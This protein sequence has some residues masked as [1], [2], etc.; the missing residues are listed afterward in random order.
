MCLK[1]NEL[2]FQ[3][4]KLGVFVFAYVLFCYVCYVYRIYSCISQSILDKIWESKT[5]GRLMYKLAKQIN[6]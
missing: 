3:K 6:K 1:E 2:S 5:G 4:Q